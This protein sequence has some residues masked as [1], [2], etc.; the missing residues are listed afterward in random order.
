[1]RITVD[2]ARCQGYANCVVG[3]PD[4]FDLGEDGKV[5]LLRAEIADAER[6]DVEDAV[7]SCPVA[8]LIVEE[9]P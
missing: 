7:H 1:M 2:L 9:T 6:A 5:H 4:V 3:S 8:A